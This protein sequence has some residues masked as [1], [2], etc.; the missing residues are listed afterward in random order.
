[1]DGVKKIVVTGPESSGKSQLSQL[2][3]QHFQT[4]HIPE[5][6][7]MYLEKNGP[8][9]NFDQL[10][11]IAKKH[12][13][14]QS[15]K[16]KEADELVFLDTDLINFSVWSQ[17]AFGK[18]DEWVEKACKLEVDHIYLILYPDLSWEPDPLREHPHQRQFLFEKHRQAVADAGRP[19]RI[20]KGLG[21]QRLENAIQATN[22]L[23]HL[24]RKNSP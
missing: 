19:Y 7:R 10:R 15:G 14:F 6:A 11:E 12:K 2:L 24:N 9:Y 16:M 17:V 5:Y 4:I 3:A 21:K 23:I 13:A 1:M 22:E 20:I 18:V 8:E